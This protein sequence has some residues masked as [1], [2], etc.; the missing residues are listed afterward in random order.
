MSTFI[1]ARLRSAA[2]CVCLAGAWG[3]TNN[4]SGET[5]R[6]L[7]PPTAERGQ[8][9]SFFIDLVDNTQPLISYGLDLELSDLGVTSGSVAINHTA[10]NFYPTQN[11]IQQ[12]GGTLNTS[13]TIDALD[14]T[15]VINAANAGTFGLA[16][17]GTGHNILAQVVIDVSA[18]AAGSFQVGLDDIAYFTVLWNES[19]QS[20][21]FSTQNS[22]ITVQ[23][24]PE[25]GCLALLGGLL[26][27]GRRSRRT[28]N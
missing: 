2:V 22:P 4:A 12:G 14:G 11:L 9:Y 8:P 15:F 25:P 1:S 24:V 13:K 3:A 28:G 26:A 6:L 21:P 16:L 17:A 5:I 23:I 18:D 10:T 19:F 27:L 20:V 7:A